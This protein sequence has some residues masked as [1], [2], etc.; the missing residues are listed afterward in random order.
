M[1]TVYSHQIPAGTT[2]NVSV[3]KLNTAALTLLSTATL[4]DGAQQ[5]T[6]SFLAQDPSLPVRVVV[7]ANRQVIRG[8]N[9]TYA[10]VKMEWSK[11]IT[12]GTDEPVIID[13]NQ[14]T[15]SVREKGEFFTDRSVLAMIA[16]QLMLLLCSDTSA[17]AEPSS[18]TL[19]KLAHGSVEVY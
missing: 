8:E 1:S 18:T 3:D 7:T 16:G 15:I 19:T 17:G 5:A 12:V 9:Y 11:T 10:S 2:Q 6:Y 4:G 14:M 13:G